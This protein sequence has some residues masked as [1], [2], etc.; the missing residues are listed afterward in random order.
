MPCAPCRHP[1][2]HLASEPEFVEMFLD[3]ARIAARIHH[4]HVVE[5]LDLG[6]EDDVFFMVMEYVEGDTLASI[7]E[8]APRVD[9]AL[10]RAARGGRSGALEGGDEELVEPVEGIAGR[11]DEPVRGHGRAATRA[12]ISRALWI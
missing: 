3:E 1:Y 6:R 7:D 4:P 2:R 8:R 12:A 11:G 5:I 9:P 10:H